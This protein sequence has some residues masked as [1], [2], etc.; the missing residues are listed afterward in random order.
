[1]KPLWIDPINRT[2]MSITEHIF[3]VVSLLGFL[4][5]I[6]ILGW[7]EPLKYRFMSRAEIYAL[8]NPQQPQQQ[9]PVA[10]NSWMWDK[11]R[12]SKLDRDAYNRGASRSSS[13]GVVIGR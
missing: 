9:A 3:R 8:E 12:K 1:V 13:G 4:G 2:E 10:A 6:F 7:N 11:T 5:L